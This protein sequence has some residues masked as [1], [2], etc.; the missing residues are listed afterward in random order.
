MSARRRRNGD[1]FADDSPWAEDDPPWAENDR[2]WTDDQRPWAD[3]EPPGREQRPGGPERPAGPSRRGRHSAAPDPG[4]AGRPAD[5]WAPEPG[6]GRLP[7]PPDSWEPP[8]GGRT[9]P[10]PAVDR[11]A[12]N[13]P[14]QSGPP[15]SQPPWPGQDAAE[16]GR[17]GLRRSPPGAPQEPE[18]PRRGSS[19]GGRYPGSR[20]QRSGPDP[21]AP[22]GN[23]RTA[24]SGP[25][26]AADPGPYPT[27][28]QSPYPAPPGA[29]AGRRDRDAVQDRRGR[30]PSGRYPDDYAGDRPQRPASPDGYGDPSQDRQARRAAPR[31]PQDPDDY[32]S[33]RDDP[34]GGY[35]EP[36]AA[37]RGP[38][39][40]RRA[41]Q[42][43]RRPEPA[44][45]YAGPPGGQAGPHDGYDD[46]SSGRV[47]A[48]DTRGA[49]RGRAGGSRS[50]RAAPPGP[51]DR[52]AGDTAR[53]AGS[54]GFLAGLGDDRPGGPGRTGRGPDGYGDDD[55]GPPG[56]GPGYG[57]GSGSGNVEYYE[58]PGG[59]D[60]GGGGGKP[61]KRKRRGRLAGPT[62]ALV[63]LIVIVVPLAI[64]G[65]F[66][67]R[68]IESHYNPPNYSGDG[69][70]Q[71]IFQVKPGDNADTI[72]PRLVSAGIVASSRAFVLAAESSTNTSVLEPGFYRMHKHMS[73]AAAWSLL[74][75]RNAQVQ[76]SVT[77]PEGW[78][79][80]QIVAELS[81]K[82]GIPASDFKAALK[83]PAALHLPSY[84]RSNPE[85]Y[86]F[87]DTYE[88]QP[89]SSATAVLQQMVTAYDHVADSDGLTAAAKHVHLTPAQVIVVASLAQAEGGTDADF[90]KIVEVI[91]NRLAQGMELD[92]DSTVMFALNTYGI[93]ASD[94]QL[95]VNSP[96]NTYKHTGLPPGPI[97]CPGNAAIEAA[98]HPPSGNLL[99]FVTVDP[100]T[101]KTEFTSSPTVFQQLKNEL[102][103]NLAQ[104]R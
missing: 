86:L 45:P 3:D 58:E 27:S 67:Y 92:L 85:G 55:Y 46:P 38:P 50:R 75:D 83:N 103:Q 64:G 36:P 29:P 59:R 43:G 52:P 78:R 12:V 9:G 80:S 10:R 20:S 74:L 72:G 49:P 1:E 26:P 68:A 7:G 89:D 63:V 31:G 81:K 95:A 102:A 5:R 24:G 99:Y 39:G 56:R 69:T 70:G 77:I 60:G 61:P 33:P 98:L 96:Y 47:P 54:G 28:G 18:P 88:L 13:L 15:D 71:V 4:L 14:R 8:R 19:S 93:A 22:A 34:R 11:P 44:D 37:R 101:K 90:P 73:A 82:S 23:R 76:A 65:F 2:P 16:T 6:G 17:Y 40:R 42:P 41:S 84:A 94:Q 48:S 79:I 100:K 53:S 35:G 25:Y 32:H 21:L 66:A 97:D 62:A 57:S 30:Q 51:G 91:Y 104:G 87:P